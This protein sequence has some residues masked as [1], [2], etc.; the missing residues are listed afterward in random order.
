ME[1][2]YYKKLLLLFALFCR[3]ATAQ[4]KDENPIVPIGAWRIHIPYYQ[5]ID[6]SGSNAKVYCATKYGLF[7]FRKDDNSIERYSR[8]NGLSDLSI[9]TIRYSKDDHLLIIAYQTSNIDLLNDDNTVINIPD[10]KDKSIEGGKSINHIF[11][12]DHKAY[13]SCSFGII[14]LDLQKK[15]I[16]DTWYIGTAGGALKVNALAYENAT[17]RFYAATD[18]GIRYAN[19]DDPSIFTYNAWKTVSTLTNPYSKYNSIAAYAGRLFVTE[20][21]I[22]KWQYDGNNWSQFTSDSLRRAFFDVFNGK[23]MLTDE[24]NIHLFDES[25]KMIGQIGYPSNDAY[26]VRGF[27]D[28]DGNFWVAGNNY[29]LARTDRWSFKEFITPNGPSGLSAYAMDSG[30][31]G[32]WVAGGAMKGSGCGDDPRGAYWFHDNHWESFYQANDAVYNSM[33]EKNLVSVAV[34][35]SDG[36]HA[37]LGSCRGGVLEANENGGAKVYDSTNSPI[38]PIRIYKTSDIWVGGVA[39]DNANNLW[40]LTNKNSQELTRTA[41]DGTWNS[42]S[43]GSSFASGELYRL[44]IDS[45]NHKW[46]YSRGMGLVVFDEGDIN[47][48]A[49][50]KT[51]ILS[52]LPKAVDGE[53]SALYPDWKPNLEFQAWAEDKDGA[54][55]VGSTEGVFVFYNPGNIM[56]DEYAHAD[57]VRIEQDGHVQFLLETEYVTAIAVDGANFKWIGT[58]S[59]GVYLMSPD[60]TKLVAHYDESNSPLLANTVRSIAIDPK[61]GEVFF[62]TDVGI[63][64]IRGTATEGG[65]HCDNYYVFPNPIKHDY[66]GPIAVK[67]LVKNA[68][69]KIADIAGQLVYETKALGGQAIWDGNNFNGDRVKTGVYVVYISNEDGSETCTTKMLFLN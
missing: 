37:F 54:I 57:R 56:T 19:A 21:E 11:I 26:P 1:L 64:S 2:K 68:S 58:L 40:I 63:C 3:A 31:D 42:F 43:L 69:V 29:G 46:I 22:I 5:G 16:K 50:D 62:G 6:V 13:L 33:A 41:P 30:S 28:D 51:V 53:I 18:S 15:E 49:D 39:Y 36:K 10:L 17:H 27:S 35:P 4:N 38:Q 23:L 52:E 44:W 45:Y 32:I 25:L 55:W 20:N 60:G 9:S 7:A 67:G 14:V 8:T 48:P 59:S 12:L 66:R 47:N 65:E 34:D 24:W 61:T